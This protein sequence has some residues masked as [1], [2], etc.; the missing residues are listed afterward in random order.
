MG[1][2]LAC[3]EKAAGSN[4]VT[5]TSSS[6]ITVLTRLPSNED[7][8][9]STERIGA[10]IFEYLVSKKWQTSHTVHWR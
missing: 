8:P 4:P 10:L 2:R 5:S 3:T 1:E 7:N 6:Q 9:A